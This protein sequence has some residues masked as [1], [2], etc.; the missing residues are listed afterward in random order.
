MAGFVPA[1]FVERK[2]NSLAFPAECSYN[3]AIFRPHMNFEWDEN[4]RQS[5]IEKHGFDFLRAKRI[6]DGRPRYDLESPRG[7]EH[8]ILSIGE[9]NGVIIAVAWTPRGADVIRIISVR[10]ARNEEE[11]NYRQIHR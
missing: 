5:N 7:G 11:R 4:K 1:I 8:R 6:F 9:L 3:V 2:T 10:R